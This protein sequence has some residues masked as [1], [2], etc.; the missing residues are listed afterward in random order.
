MNKVIFSDDALSVVVI[1]VLPKLPL[2]SQSMVGKRTAK[3][4]AAQAHLLRA[5]F[6]LIERV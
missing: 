5:Y 4:H 1:V 6:F 2:V 3:V